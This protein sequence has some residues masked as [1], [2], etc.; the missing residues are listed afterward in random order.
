MESLLIVFK[1]FVHYG[2]HFL[3]PGLIAYI[4]FKAEW[5]KAWMLMLAS[6][7]VDLDHLFANPIFEANRCSINFHPLHTY[8]AML[9]YVVF[10]YFPK[11]RIIALGLLFHMLTD[12]IDCWIV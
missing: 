11:I 5:K 3:F 8:Y 10:L 9:I 2:L 12:W 4:F 6:M 7:L 1:P